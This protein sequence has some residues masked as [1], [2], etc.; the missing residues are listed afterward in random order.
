MKMLISGQ[1]CDGAADCPLGDDE[2]GLLTSDGVPLQCREPGGKCRLY[3]SRSPTSPFLAGRQCSGGDCVEEELWCSQH[4][5]CPHCED[6]LHCQAWLC[7]P[8]H[9]KCS[10]S[11]LCLHPAK[12]CDGRQD[13]GD[14]SDEH[15]CPCDLGEPSSS[16][17]LSQKLIRDLGRKCLINPETESGIKSVQIDR[18][19]SDGVFLL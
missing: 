10:S 9:F 2:V 5:H 4:C 15:D 13:C 7:P 19:R 11:G 1:V 17:G 8:R 16:W 12:V 6:Q 14:G 3:Q 18:V